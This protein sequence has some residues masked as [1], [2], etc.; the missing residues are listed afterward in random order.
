MCGDRGLTLVSSFKAEPVKM[1]HLKISEPFKGWISANYEWFKCDVF[2]EA[3]KLV[4]TRVQGKILF[5]R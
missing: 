2:T 4:G 1:H 3:V 5:Q